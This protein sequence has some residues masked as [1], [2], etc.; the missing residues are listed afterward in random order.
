MDAS[1]DELESFVTIAQLGAFGRASRKLRRSQ[2]AI[3]RRIAQL[4]QTMGVP[5]FARVGRKVTLTDAGKTLLPF[6]EA[7]LAAVRDGQRAV[8]DH[9]DRAHSPSTLRLAIVGTLADTHVVDALR[10]FRRKYPRASVDLRTAASREVS[11]LVRSG[12]AALGLRF[13]RDSDPALESVL[14]GAERLFVVVPASHPVKQKRLR[15]PS[16]FDGET[17]L[18]FPPNRR[19]PE[20]Y[21]HVV[22]TRLAAAGFARPSIN[23]VDSL[24]AQKRLVQA[25]LGIAL[26]PKS[27]VR[28]EARL[29]S[30]RLIEVTGLGAEI[31]VVLV[32]RK[33]GYR[34]RLADDFLAL[35]RKYVPRLLE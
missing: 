10:A 12:D 2:P 9:S 35:L 4:E 30:L 33:G 32:R 15:D 26:M 34:D 8:R 17:W 19:E 28:E 11:A 22:E 13:F 7:A 27:S 16:V 31:P 23:L 3:S 25:G 20:S 18:T 6:A 5:L 24:T 1:F 29:G 21:G 14:L